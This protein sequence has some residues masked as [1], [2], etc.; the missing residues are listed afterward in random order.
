MSRFVG[1]GFP[2][3]SSPMLELVGKSILVELKLP[4]FSTAVELLG[5]QD[6]DSGSL[7]S[8][9]VDKSGT[10]FLLEVPTLL[11]LEIILL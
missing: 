11:S 6:V 9:L 8:L 3:D 2:P 4:P 1:V 7:L 10:D 5:S